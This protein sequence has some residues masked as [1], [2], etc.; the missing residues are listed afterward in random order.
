MNEVKDIMIETFKASAM[1]GYSDGELRF[2]DDILNAIF[3]VMFPNEYKDTYDN[4]IKE[5]EE[6]DKDF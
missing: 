1:I 6:K 3:R 5:K 2:N 4:L